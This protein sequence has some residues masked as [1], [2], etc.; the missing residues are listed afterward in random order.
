MAP[1]A[2]ERAQARRAAERAARAAEE[3][4]PLVKKS[5]SLKPM[6]LP[7]EDWPPGMQTS[8]DDPL[9]IG[10]VCIKRIEHLHRKLA[11]I[12]AEEEELKKLG[13]NAEPDERAE[14]KKRVARLMILECEEELLKSRMALLHDE[15]RNM[16]QREERRHHSA[17]AF[18]K[19]QRPLVYL[20]YVLAATYGAYLGWVVVHTPHR[21]REK[22]HPDGYT[23]KACPSA[24]AAL[25]DRVLGEVEC[26]VRDYSFDWGNK[27][28]EGILPL[29]VLRP[30]NAS[31]VAAAVVLA[32]EHGVP[33]SYRSGGHS[34]TC[35]SIK[36]G[37]LHV[38]LRSLSDVEL[39]GKEVSF[40]TGNNMRTLLDALPE[41]KMIV[42]GQCP[43]VGAGGL[44]LHGGYHTTLTLKYGRGNDTVTAMEVVTA[45]G[46]VRQLSDAS[47]AGAE[48]QLWKAMRQAGSSFAIA[49]RITVKVI[50]DL[51]Q[52]S[53]T[54]G[55]D[56]FA[57][58]VPRAQM[59]GLLR[60][61]TH[62]AGLLNYIHVNGVDFLIAAASTRFEENARWLE[63]VLGRELTQLE[64][65]RSY[66]VHVVEQPASDHAGADGRFGKSGAVPY[67]FSTQEAFADVSF[68]MP[69]GC[70]LE[71]KMQAL[72]AALPD[73]RDGGTDLGCYLQ[74][75]TTY[76]P[77]GEP[78]A[79]FVDY[80]C[81]YESDF[82]RARQ[83]QLNDEVLALCP[84]GMRRYVNTPSE[85]LT[86]RD[87]YPNYDWLAE[88]KSAWDPA[89]AFRVYQGIRPTGKP[90]DAYE[91]SR[92]YV[93]GRSLIDLA[94]EIGWDVVA[95]VVLQP[96]RPVGR[97]DFNILGSLAFLTTVL[98]ILC[99]F[100]C[101]VHKDIKQHQGQD[102]EFEHRRKEFR[103]NLRGAV[104]APLGKHDIA[105]RVAVPPLLS[106]PEA[107]P[108]LVGKDGI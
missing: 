7:N 30:E 45:D 31:D 61:A 1:A 12:Q 78:P 40:G 87:Y 68:I 62:E 107:E 13:S 66:F 29:C 101:Y 10:L 42:H 41:G 33:L 98:V 69:M 25:K 67:V 57:V 20:I 15:E 22:S 38:D 6:L 11:E 43:T 90:P 47:P 14:A 46:K 79:A 89:E 26:N 96:N 74:V 58:E 19:H 49:T 105:D 8:E 77:P 18:G 60:N 36:A 92:P 48:Q 72:L 70:F 81:P 55:G 80:N 93:R 50:D 65:L 97:A 39:H 54:D 51:P 88:V 108:P 59:L 76:V 64:W 94:G 17:I 86:P 85:F 24:C 23:E 100:G 83:R 32:N 71:P 99:S 82:Y 56:F 21:F 91:F 73:A 34:Y 2:A 106:P 44:F 4:R 3:N 102:E 103:A 63:T 95:R 35:N 84:K 5:N 52:D 53:P 27:I 9:S 37:S 28:C 16:L 104:V 75:T